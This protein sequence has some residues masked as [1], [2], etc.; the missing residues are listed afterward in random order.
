[1]SVLQPSL[2]YYLALLVL[3]LAGSVTA[4]TAPVVSSR[5]ELITQLEQQTL[6]QFILAADGPIIRSIMEPLMRR[7]TAL[8]QA[9]W[10]AVASEL[11]ANLIKEF[12]RPK[13]PFDLGFTGSMQA[14]SDADLQ[15]LTQLLKDPLLTRFKDAQA[16]MQLHKALSAEL[17]VSADAVNDAINRIAR[18]HH[19][20]LP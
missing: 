14:F 17:S 9:D 5:A 3:G 10:Q 7:N 6:S 4:Q 12:M 16:S 13:Q 1:M 19:L 20:R 15:Q 8:S 2:R 11:Q 18:E